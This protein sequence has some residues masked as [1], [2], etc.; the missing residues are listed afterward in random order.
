[1][2]MAVGAHDS[3]LL[4]LA[5]P[6]WPGRNTDLNLI[7]HS[8]SAPLCIHFTSLSR[9]YRLFYPPVVCNVAKAARPKGRLMSSR[10]LNICP[11]LHP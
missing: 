8:T 4:P 3:V 9:S 7:F 2:L 5:A 1:M 11:T 6:G 10:L